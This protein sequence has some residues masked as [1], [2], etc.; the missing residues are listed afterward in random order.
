MQGEVENAELWACGHG[1]CSDV[2]RD[3]WCAVFSI[4]LGP[5][6]LY[7]NFIIGLNCMAKFTSNV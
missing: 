2:V 4:K 7:I 5:A 1:R 3:S 6:L